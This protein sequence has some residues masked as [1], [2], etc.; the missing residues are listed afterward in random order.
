[1]HLEDQERTPHMKRRV[2]AMTTAGAVMAGAVFALLWSSSLFVGPVAAQG[3]KAPAAKNGASTAVPRMADGHPDLSGVWWGGGDVG[4]ARGRGPVPFG[5]ARGG[6]RGT[7]PP[8][9][10]AS[11]YKPEAAQQ[12]KTLGDKD[13]PT[14]RCVP[15]AFGT[16]NVSL[17]DVGAVGQIVATPKMIV[18]LTETYHGYRLV[19][20]DG[21]AHR[22]DQPPA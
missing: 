20:T 16:L 8:Q 2:V 18:M 4:A 14:L 11:L 10:F 3:A 15:T 7:T 9:T 13:D 6:G 1:M 21:R 17:W 12:A 5:G 22:D 19:P